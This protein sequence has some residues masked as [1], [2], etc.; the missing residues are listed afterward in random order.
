MI[1]TWVILGQV[2]IRI[3]FN[4]IIM[5]WIYAIIRYYCVIVTYF[6]RKIYEANKMKVLQKK[7]RGKKK[8]I[9]NMPR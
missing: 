9:F 8:K 7:G 2:I 6:P 1:L 5:K 3:A 4:F